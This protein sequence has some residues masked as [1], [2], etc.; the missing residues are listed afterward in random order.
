[1]LPEERSKQEQILKTRTNIYRIRYNEYCQD[2]ASAI[3]NARYPTLKEDSNSTKPF[4]LPVHNWTSHYRTAFEYLVTYW[5]ENP[6]VVTTDRILK[7]TRPY[8]DKMTG[9]M[10]YPR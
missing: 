8:K 3:L 7:D 2:F 10:I 1:M 6:L 5:L 4:V 9:Q